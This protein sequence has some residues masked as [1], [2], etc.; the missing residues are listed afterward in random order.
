MLP[1]SSG[2]GRETDREARG[3]G[4][5]TDREALNSQNQSALQS[6]NNLFLNIN[7]GSQ[8]NMTFPQPKDGKEK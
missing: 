5:E 1:L 4:R 2:S 8:E 6:K 3:S 7:I